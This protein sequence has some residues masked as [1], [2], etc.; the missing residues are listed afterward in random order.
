MEGVAYRMGVVG[1]AAVGGKPGT[2]DKGVGR[3][4]NEEEIS[5]PCWW[6]W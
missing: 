1:E 5:P 3:D 4:G 2:M 6:C